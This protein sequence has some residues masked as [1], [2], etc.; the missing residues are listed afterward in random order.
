LLNEGVY[1]LRNLLKVTNFYDSVQ[2]ETIKG[3]GWKH[4]V[5]GKY[6]E[7]EN[8]ADLI[9]NPPES[10]VPQERMDID[11]PG[12]AWDLL[13]YKN[14][15]F[16]L[17][18]SHFWH[19]DFDHAKRTPAAAIYTSL[20]CPFGC[21]FCMINI[22]NRRDNGEHISS[23]DSKGIRYWGIDLITKEFEKLA[24][25]GVETVRLSDE[26]FFLKQSHFEP[27]LTNLFDR[28]LPLRMWAYSRIDT[29]Q[30]KHLELFK[31]AG[32]NWLAL[33]IEAANQNI[34]LEI[35]KGKFQNT[36]IRDVVKKIESANINI[37][38]NYILGFPDD[39]METMNETLNLALELNSAMVN[40]YPCQ[41]LPG[42]PLYIQAKKNGLALPEHPN[43]FAFLSYECKPLPTK[44]LT[45]QQI[46]KFRDEF[47]HRCCSDPRYLQSL[48]TKF[49]KEAR[50]NM[51]AL[52]TINLK[53]K[54]LGD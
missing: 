35:T 8:H 33:G 36:N 26:M 30:E 11:L 52:T 5:L 23:E 37:I 10:V 2:L 29:V 24:A 6:A 17:Y 38:A 42:S 20:G 50:T 53:R 28:K 21:S 51:E 3:I 13:P 1:A 32:V 54:L 39:N 7:E 49:G 22:L 41:A 34:R 12:Y 40:V 46:L 16:D 18:K 4:L 47:W 14:K 45:P 27:L 44:Y 31:K 25:Y 19:A 43:E 9:L 48:E 15:P